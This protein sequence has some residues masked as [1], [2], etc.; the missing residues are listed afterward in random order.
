[1]VDEYLSEREQAEQLRHWLR[2][3]WIWL[4][5]GVALTVGGYYGYRAWQSRESSRAVE[6]GQ[7]FSSMLEA[8][9][10]DRRDE[11]LRLAGELTGEYA[12]TPYADQATLV[13]ARLDVDSGDLASA[14]RRL[15]GIAEGSKDPDLRIV[16]RLRLARVQQ[17][18]GRYDDA[19][20]SLDAVATPAVD[21]RV[22]ELRGDVRRSQGDAAAAL[23]EWHKAKAAAEAEPDTGAQVDM[24][25]L[26]LKI[27]ELAAAQPAE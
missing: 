26:Q 15:A 21:A 13:L 16:A 18:Q 2:D 22:L 8:I 12:D 20:A 27:D 25:L 1:M 19:L 9:G 14:E 7:L 11:G 10:G 6:A 17:A 4:V 23:S 5:A 24:E 3:N